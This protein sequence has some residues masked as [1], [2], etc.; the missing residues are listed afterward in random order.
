MAKRCT[1]CN[2]WK[3][4]SAF[5]KDK[6][7]LDGL[8]SHCKPCHESYK[9]GYRAKPGARSLRRRLVIVRTVTE[10]W[11]A[12]SYRRAVLAWSEDRR[13]VQR[14][15]RKAYLKKWHR[16]NG[17]ASRI[18]NRQNPESATAFRQSARTQ[19]LHTP[20]NS[21]T[22][23]EWGW[24]LSRY[25]HRC[26]YC[27]LPA[28]R[29]SP[30]H[31]VPLAR[32]GHNTLSNIAPACEACNQRKNDRTPDEAGMRFAVRIDTLREMEQLALMGDR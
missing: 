7:K 22:A 32:G 6:S 23:E 31:I 3:D 28:N 20:I 21:L 1:R 17:Q 11:P 12:L 19:A 9:S 25:D 2:L 13:R 27:G 8:K 26:A 29:L 14:E 10:R 30:D 16:Q 15:R 18:W 4:D 5:Y 24:L